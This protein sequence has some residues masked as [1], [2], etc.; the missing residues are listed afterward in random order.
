M[1]DDADARE[2]AVRVEPPEKVA[3]DFPTPMG[4]A[5]ACYPETNPLVPLDHVAA[6]SNTPAS[7][8]IVIRMEK[9]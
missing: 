1:A 6:T 4:N 2:R 8:S 7:K 3:A 9:V 5:A